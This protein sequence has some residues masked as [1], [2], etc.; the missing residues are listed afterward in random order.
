MWFKGVIID[1]L[2]EYSKKYQVEVHAFV[3]TTHHVHLR[4]TPL[5]QRGVSQLLQSLGRYYVRLVNHT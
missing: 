4:L 5:T 2:K 1:R 3:L